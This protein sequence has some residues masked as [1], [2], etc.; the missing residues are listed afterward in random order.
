MAIG[1]IS[2]SIACVRVRHFHEL[3]DASCHLIENRHD[4]KKAAPESE[5][6]VSVQISPS[7][8]SNIRLGYNLRDRAQKRVHPAPYETAR[9]FAAGATKSLITADTINTSLTPH[10]ANATAQPSDLSTQY[11]SSLEQL[12]LEE[13]P[14]AVPKY[15]N[16]HRCCCRDLERDQHSWETLKK[17][18]P[19][20]LFY[21]LVFA[22]AI[23]CPRKPCFYLVTI[24]WIL[25]WSIHVFF[26]LNA[27]STTVVHVLCY[28]KANCQVATKVFGLTNLIAYV[29]GDGAF[30]MQ[31]IFVHT[32]LRDLLQSRELQTLIFSVHPDRIASE[33]CWYV[34][35]HEL[36]ISQFSSWA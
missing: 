32:F 36:F 30:L 15:T 4:E 27:L 29:L 1:S 9:P 5:D 18:F 12:Y 8:S 2:T 22:G 19:P 24:F 21:L 16:N 20:F 28:F 10:I 35:E 6:V 34:L 23:P 13:W 3:K 14:G 11:D 33:L 7:Q 26:S 31:I 25:L 17:V